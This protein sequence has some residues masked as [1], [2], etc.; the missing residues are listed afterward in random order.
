M[1]RLSQFIKYLLLLVEVCKHRKTSFASEL[2]TPHNDRLTGCDGNIQ[3][4]WICLTHLGIKKIKSIH[5]SHTQTHT[6]TEIHHIS[7]WTET[8][9]GIHA[10]SDR[11]HKIPHHTLSHNYLITTSLASQFRRQAWAMFT[12]NTLNNTKRKRKK[13]RKYNDTRNAQKQQKKC[14][15]HAGSPKDFIVQLS[16]DINKLLLFLNSW[17]MAH[18]VQS[19]SATVNLVVWEKVYCYIKVWHT[20]D[21]LASNSPAVFS[22]WH[23][24]SRT[25]TV[26]RYTINHLP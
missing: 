25:L 26:Y 19:L 24:R 8:L 12:Q 22:V 11:F 7:F 21:F 3:V 6:D 15:L 20:A 16:C 18:K 23:L 5:T 17:F 9:L 14:S 13:K 10:C 4:P 1:C 2:G